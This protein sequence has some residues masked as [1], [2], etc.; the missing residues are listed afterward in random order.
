MADYLN[1]GGDV[2]FPT[3]LDADGNVLL[4]LHGDTFTAPDGLVVDSVSVV[5]APAETPVEPEVSEPDLETEETPADASP[6]ED[7]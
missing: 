3:L 6:T 1:N 4:V 2:V 7:K 5:G